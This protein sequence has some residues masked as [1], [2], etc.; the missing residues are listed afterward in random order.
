MAIPRE[1]KPPR[2]SDVMESVLERGDAARLAFQL[3]CEEFRGNG[4]FGPLDRIRTLT[5]MIKEDDGRPDRAYPIGHYVARLLDGL[6]IPLPKVCSGP[7]SEF[8]NH[9]SNVLKETGEAVERIR[10]AWLEKTPGK[11][12]VEEAAA[13]RKEVDEA[14][15]ALQSLRLWIDANERDRA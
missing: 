5:S 2:A 8:I 13:S 4:K 12:C 1:T 11:L 6:F 9:I 7:D 3:S 10:V 15:A 14:M